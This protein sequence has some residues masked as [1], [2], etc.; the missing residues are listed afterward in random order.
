MRANTLSLAPLAFLA[1]VV[2]AQ[3]E[4]YPHLIIYPVEDEPYNFTLYRDPRG[5]SIIHLSKHYSRLL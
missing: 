4:Y 1:S 2:R 3:L 5:T